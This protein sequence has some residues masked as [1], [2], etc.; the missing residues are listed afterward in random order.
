[1]KKYYIPIYIYVYIIYYNPLKKDIE[2]HEY[3]SIYIN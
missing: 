2:V 1:M 3:I